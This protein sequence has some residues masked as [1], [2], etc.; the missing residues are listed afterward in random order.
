[1]V[2]AQPGMSDSG[3]PRWRLFGDGQDAIRRNLHCCGKRRDPVADSVHNPLH[4]SKKIVQ[5][6]NI[7]RTISGK[8]SVLAVRDV[9]HGR[10]VRNTEA[11]ANPEA[12]ELYDSVSVRD[13]L[14]A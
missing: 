5:V 8:I 9:I 13:E 7:P 2:D 12:L 6:S 3:P 4:V 11:L 1:M 10:P 14:D